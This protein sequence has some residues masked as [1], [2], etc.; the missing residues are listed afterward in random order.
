VIE[1]AHSL[2]GITAKTVRQKN[3]VH[4]YF[5]AP[6]HLTRGKKHPIT[7]WFEKLRIERVRSYK[8]QV[9]EAIFGCSKARSALFLRHLWSTDGNISKKVMPRR[10]PSVSIY[11]A[12]SS[13][14]L[15]EQV[16]HLLLRLNIRSTMRT[17]PSAKGYRT[18]YHVCVEGTPNQLQF[19]ETVGIADERAHYIQHYIRTLKAIEP[20]TNID[21]IPRE[22][23]RLVIAPAKEAE[24]LSWRDVAHKLDIAYNGSALM[25]TGIGRDRLATIGTLLAS[26]TCLELATSDAKLNILIKKVRLIKDI[27]KLILIKVRYSNKADRIRNRYLD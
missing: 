24:N 26:K 27:I 13:K 1:A 18:M 7:T 6:F 15:A 22:A 21:T 5:T 3:W 10:K 8:K 12:S 20:N 11:Y 25:Q 17:V 23:W 4:V 14:K 9:P 16:G 2:F 19:L